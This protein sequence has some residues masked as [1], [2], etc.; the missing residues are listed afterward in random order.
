MC[1]DRTDCWLKCLCWLQNVS[2]DI[3]GISRICQNTCASL[4]MQMLCKYNC[5]ISLKRTKKTYPSLSHIFKLST[6]FLFICTASFPCHSRLVSCNFLA[7]QKEKKRIIQ[8]LALLLRQDNILA[9]TAAWKKSLWCKSILIL[10]FTENKLSSTVRK[11][12]GRKKYPPR[13]LPYFAFWCADLPTQ[14]DVWICSSHSF[15]KR[16]SC[17]R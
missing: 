1:K 4:Q 5:V 9:V 16:K 11:N 6:L 2:L 14:I 10:L 7:V 3:S 12:Q 15:S 13:P 8:I 17:C